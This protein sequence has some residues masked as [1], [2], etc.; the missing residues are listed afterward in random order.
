MDLTVSNQWELLATITDV[1]VRTYNDYMLQA[2]RQY[3]YS[4]TQVATRSGTL[5]ES[6]VGFWL[7]DQDQPV[8]EARVCDV[9]L[10]HYW[11]INPDDTPLSL[12]LVNVTK[13]SM[14]DEYE[15][16]TFQIIGRGRHT[17]YGDRLGYSGTL[18]CQVRIPERPSSF[19]KA[20]E[21][22]RRANE[23]YWLRD[24]FG[25]LFKVSLGDLSWDPVAGVGT[26]EF[27]DMSIPYEEVA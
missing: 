22:L 2:G 1:T 19:K 10:T 16:E 17:D 7:N 20:V 13:N 4:A 15:S 3:L 6:P 24:P 5:L 14:T 8:I 11:I 27:G 18:E 23:T 26:V 21:D 12:R 25:A 9:D